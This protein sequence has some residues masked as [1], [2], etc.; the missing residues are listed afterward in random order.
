MPASSVQRLPPD[1]WPQED[2]ETEAPL[3][4]A[5]DYDVARRAFK[6]AHGYAH[7]PGEFGHQRW[8]DGW[9]YGY[10]AGQRKVKRAHSAGVAPGE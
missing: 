1:M 2:F 9:I 10:E 4:R 5:S 8:L 6:R 3:V 7:R